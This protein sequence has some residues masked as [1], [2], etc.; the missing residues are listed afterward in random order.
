MRRADGHAR[1]ADIDRKC[2]CDRAHS[3]A[4]KRTARVAGPRARQAGGLAMSIVGSALLGA[5]VR[6]RNAFYERGL[7]KPRH[8]AWPLISIGNPAV[9]GSGTSPLPILPGTL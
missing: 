8:L 3:I 1:P 6:P 5:G 7:V 4:P 9:G 2:R